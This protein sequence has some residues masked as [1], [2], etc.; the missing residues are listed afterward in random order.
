MRFEVFECF[1][2]VVAINKIATFI[3]DKSI[4]NTVVMQQ[5]TQSLS[6][7]FKNLDL[8][9]RVQGGEHISNTVV[10]V[11]GLWFSEEKTWI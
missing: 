10:N 4:S 7:P 2:P 1:S 11:L 3:I 6:P 9:F 8:G 5:Q